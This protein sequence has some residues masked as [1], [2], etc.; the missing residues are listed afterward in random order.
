LHR[1]SLGAVVVTVAA[2][3]LAGCSSSD[4]PTESEVVDWGSLVGSVSS[5]RGGPVADIEVH[6]WGDVGAGG[7]TGQYDAVTDGEGQYEIEEIDLSWAVSGTETYELY[8]NRTKNSALPIN[9][10]YRGYAATV[11]IEIGE[12]TTAD[13]VIIEEGPIV[14]EQFLD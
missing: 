3:A 12:V 4:S 9:A 5:D 13:V 11:T 1:A 7:A 14:P 6:L 2:V 8:V 10:V